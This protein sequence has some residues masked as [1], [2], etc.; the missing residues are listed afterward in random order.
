M[1]EIELPFFA[2]QVHHDVL[3]CRGNDRLAVMLVG[4]G[5]SRVWTLA[6]RDMGGR[7]S[8]VSGAKRHAYSAGVELFDRGLV[9]IVDRRLIPV[10]P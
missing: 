9:R 10:Q 7:F 4:D 3:G 2:R 1:S 6:Q 5:V 8:P